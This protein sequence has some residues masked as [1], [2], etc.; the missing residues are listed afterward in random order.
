MEKMR[1]GRTGLT[2]S[3]S[4]FGALP[5]Q[6]ASPQDA[7]DILCAAHENGI[8]FFDTARAYSDSEE[9]IGQA[10]AGVRDEI[11]IATK[12]HAAN[13]G[14]L[15]SHLET[16]LRNLK[17]DYVDI[18][19]LHNPATLP[20][21]RDPDGLYGALRSAQK[22]GMTRYIGMTNHRRAVALEA[23]RSGQ[24]DTV[25]FPFSYLSADEDRELV[26]EC[27]KHDIGFIAMK[28]LSGGL[29][30]NIAA[31]FTYLRQ[32]DVVLPIWGIQRMSELQEFIELEK[33]P[34]ALDEQMRDCIEQDRRELC[35]EFCRGCGYCL[36]CPADIPI[37]MAARLS[38]ALKRMPWR[39]FMQPEWK[40]QMEKIRECQDCGHCRQHCP[41]GL[42]TPAL[43]KKMLGEYEEFYAQHA[44]EG[45]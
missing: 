16:S 31:T 21:P 3:R 1:L 38:F 20:D 15:I 41:Y 36:P 45:R 13:A 39:Q 42:D 8:D 30:S 32:F 18:L 35:G 11:V 9:K 28:A 17:T 22:K 14:D 34:P 25:Q 23:V 37:P 27:R 33:S 10:L 26:D 12:S 43:L 24:Y 2:V 29:V 44:E 19:Q 7:H 4:G 5:I 6:R 40:K